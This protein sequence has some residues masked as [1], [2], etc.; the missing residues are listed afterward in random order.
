MDRR[1]DLFVCFNVIR[2]RVLI[3]SR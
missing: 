3:V 2:Q 1:L